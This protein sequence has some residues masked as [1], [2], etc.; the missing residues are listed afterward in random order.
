M[1]TNRS[2]EGAWNFADHQWFDRKRFEMGFSA[3]S[4]EALSTALGRISADPRAMVLLAAQK[5]RAQWGN[6][7]V[8]VTF[9]IP[10]A[11]APSLAL[12]DAWALSLWL[13]AL[14]RVRRA[15]DLPPLERLALAALAGTVASH[16]LLEANP[17][18]AL[19]WMVGLVFVAAAAPRLT[20]TP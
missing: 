9:A 2:S 19:P 12:A 4:R 10:A 6:G 8:A 11:G 16:L 18:Y 13:L 15:P 3:A 17:R 5:F 1:G 14:W 20:R 7:A